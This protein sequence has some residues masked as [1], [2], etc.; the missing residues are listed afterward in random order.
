M[1]YYF[2]LLI[3]FIC[4]LPA[5]IPIH[6]MT[7]DK[8]QIVRVI[9][10]LYLA[11]QSCAEIKPAD[12]AVAAFQRVTKSNFT[13]VADIFNK[14]GY[15]GYDFIGKDASDK[16]FVLVQHS[17]FNVAF[18]Q[19]VL[20]KMEKEVLNGNASGEN[21]AFLTDRTEINSGRQQIYGTQV[22]MSGN[23]VIKPCIDTANLDA[24]R[25]SVGLEP[26]QD[27]I[28]M[29]NEMFYLLNPQEK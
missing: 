18:Q 28:N 20:S 22:F 14:Y 27:Y 5:C 4:V 8:T 19:Q 15:P 7:A 3:C 12:S 17:D 11:D 2:A 6:K 23:T 24:R 10:S 26:I 25:K 29:C 16:Y 9:D 13:I 1:K 21:F